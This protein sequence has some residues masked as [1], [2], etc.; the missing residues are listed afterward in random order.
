ML[1]NIID[2]QSRDF[3]AF[4]KNRNDVSCFSLPSF[5]IEVGTNQWNLFQARIVNTSNLMIALMLLLALI[6]V[7]QLELVENNL[8]SIQRPSIDLNE[9]AS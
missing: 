3:V 7:N 8:D 1:L 6:N 2:I 5:L 9:R 4:L